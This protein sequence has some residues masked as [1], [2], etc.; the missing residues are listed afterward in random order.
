MGELG[1][2]LDCDLT[3]KVA[4]LSSGNKRKIGLISAFMARL[5]LL[6]LDEPTSGLDPLDAARGRAPGLGYAAVGVGTP[7]TILKS[8][9]GEQPW[10]RGS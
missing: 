1:E 10:H 2:R 8:D 3:K 7:R 4:D 9:R 6:I 5:E